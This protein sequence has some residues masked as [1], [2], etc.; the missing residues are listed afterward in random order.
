ME[1]M[2]VHLICIDIWLISLI[3]G[4]VSDI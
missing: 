1:L 2:L 4:V 3:S